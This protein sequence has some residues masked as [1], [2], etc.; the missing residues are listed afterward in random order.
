VDVEHLPLAG[1]L[2]AD[3]GPDLRVV[4]GAGEGE[5]GVA[6]LGRGGDHAHLAD[7]GDRHL[8]RARDRGG[9]HGE[10]VD[11]EAHLLQRLLVLDA[12]ALLLVDDHQAEVLELD[13]LGEQTVRADDD[14]DLA[15]GQAVD[16]LLRLG[17][18]LEPAQ[19]ATVT[20]KPA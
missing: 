7:A 15:V 20:G 1:Q 16:D 8:Q 10:H 17:R 14:V 5:H 6:L 18:G 12:E 4:A 2:A 13:L 9:R 3:R 11:V 19:R